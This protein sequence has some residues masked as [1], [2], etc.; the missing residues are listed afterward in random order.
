MSAAADT[1]RHNPDPLDRIAPALRPAEAAIGYQTWT[2]LLFVHW[3]IPAVEIAPLIPRQL[4][5]DTFDGSAWVGLVAFRMS[6]VRPRW[7]P[8]VPGV[9]AFLETNVRTYVHHAGRDPG[10]WFFSLDANGSVAVP[11]GRWKWNLPYFRSAMQLVWSNSVVTYRSRRW[12]PGPFG[13]GYSI[14][15]E[16]G[17]L[18]NPA[19]TDAPLPRGKVRP[20]TLEHFLAERYLLY[21]TDAAGR[22]YR[23]QVHHA[24]YPLR[25]ARLT[26]CGETLLAP[27]GITAPAPPDHT[28][29]SDGV[30]VEIFKL[31]PL[32]GAPRM[33]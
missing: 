17:D 21:T 12:W 16:I 23:G 33:E 22:V 30:S 13:A 3:R 11:L 1:R 18:L 29:F 8:A 10:V 15:A 27:C 4:T 26:D 9:S 32:P 19:A 2:D 20:G 31:R 28:L 5:V 25:E 7:F 24:A 6:G 14:S